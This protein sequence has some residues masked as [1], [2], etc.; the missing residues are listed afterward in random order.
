[1]FGLGGAYV[2][3]LRDVSFRLS[4]MWEV[5]AEQMIKSVKAYG[6]LQGVRGK[7]QSDMAAIK[8]CILRISQMITENPEIAELD[9]NP[10]IVYPRG[11]GCVAADC[12]ILLRKE[13]Q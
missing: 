3:A 7:P 9:I 6:I 1:M 8:D 13:V 4:P 5:S 10:L 12:R 2:E 11:E